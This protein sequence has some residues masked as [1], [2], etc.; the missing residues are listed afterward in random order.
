MKS[1]LDTVIGT[2]ARSDRYWDISCADRQRY[3]VE[4][5]YRLGRSDIR[6]EIVT[7]LRRSCFN[8]IRVASNAPRRRKPS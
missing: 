6:R 2:A 5:A 8:R 1:V 7:A 3:L 4:M